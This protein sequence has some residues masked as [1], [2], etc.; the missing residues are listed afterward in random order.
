MAAFISVVITSATI[1]HFPDID[2]LPVIFQSHR[3]DA[4]AL[5]C[6][7]K[8]RSSEAIRLA[9]LTLDCFAEPVIGRAFAR[10][11]SQ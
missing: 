4:L 8:E 6:N 11:V 7:Y 2:S 10:P 1:I 5:R 3:S 9:T